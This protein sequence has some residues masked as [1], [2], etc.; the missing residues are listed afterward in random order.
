MHQAVS[1]TQVRAQQVR[2][3]VTW[4]QGSATHWLSSQAKQAQGCWGAPGLLHNNLLFLLYLPG[5]N[6]HSTAR[7]STAQQGMM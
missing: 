3:H 6:L 1:N 7:H 4:P 2:V 5:R